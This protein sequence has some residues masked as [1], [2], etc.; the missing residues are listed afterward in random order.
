MEPTGPKITLFQTEAKHVERV[1]A[2]ALVLSCVV[3]LTS[4]VA[5][6]VLTAN[7]QNV[8]DELR[9]SM[10]EFNVSERIS[11]R[12]VEHFTDT[13][14][15]CVA[16]LCELDQRRASTEATSELRWRVW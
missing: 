12:V 13:C 5:S 8:G 9:S 16:H 1:A 14:R 3:V 11:T 4:L 10:N 15:R 2:V 6:L 7:M